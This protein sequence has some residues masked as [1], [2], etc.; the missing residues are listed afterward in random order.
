MEKQV[1]NSEKLFS[2]NTGE[3]KIRVRFSETD[4]MGITWH[5]NYFSWF[6][7]GRTELLRNAGLSYR[8]LEESGTMFAVVSA[9]CSYK[10]PAMYDDVLTLKTRVIKITPIRIEHEYRL[11][12]DSLLLAVGKTVLASVD[13]EGKIKPIPSSIV[14]LFERQNAEENEN[15]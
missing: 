9:E 11:F 8:D 10:H 14:E 13:S 5:G 6:E 15:D 7:M 12:R 4:K 1:N 2:E 3:I